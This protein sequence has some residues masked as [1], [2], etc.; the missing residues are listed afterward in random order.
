MLFLRRHWIYVLQLFFFTGLA[1]AAPPMI[2]WLLGHTSPTLFGSATG[3]AIT[4]LF[5][6]MYYLAV[7]TFFFQEFIDYYLDV[8]IVTNERVINIEQL[9]LFNRVASEMHIAL[10][11]DITTEIQGPL[12]TFLNFGD[13]HVQS[14]GQ[15]KRFHFKAVH[16][17]EQIRAVILRLAEEDRA[18]ESLTR[19]T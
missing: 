16:R 8:W 3:S 17:P 14:A 13:V 15:I 18:R 10:V 11:Q 6:S 9:G 2:T 12:R 4:L 19:A 5:I 1:A 7:T